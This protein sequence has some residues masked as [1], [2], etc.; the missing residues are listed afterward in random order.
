METLA[1]FK[2]V[3]DEIKDAGGEAYKRCFQCG[4]CD[5]ICPWNR[6]KQFSV[7]KIVRQATFGIS[8]IESDNLW[9]CTTCGLCQDRCP[10]DV[11]QI[12]LGTALRRVAS[13]YEVFPASVKSVRSARASLISLGNPIQG[14]RENRAHWAKDL[15]VKPF[16]QG[17]E[18]LFFVGCYLSYDPRMKKVAIATANILNNA[19][20]KFGILGDK[21]NCCGESIRKTGAEEVFQQLAKHNIK[22]FIDKGVKKII[23]SSPHCYHT[24]KNEYSEFPVSFLY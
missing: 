15:E 19:G 4:L 24:F 21:E 8:E 2:E 5:T 6:V 1:P 12:E 16:E 3:V 13:N 22:T 10:R 23:V 17:M 20:V 9:T 14:E 11:K 7:R 18:V